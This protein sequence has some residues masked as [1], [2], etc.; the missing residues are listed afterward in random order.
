[1]RKLSCALAALAIAACGGQDSAS[2]ISEIETLPADESV[3]TPGNQLAR[4]AIDSPANTAAPNP[5]AAMPAA[6]HG[7][8]GLT[9]EDC[10]STRGDAKGLVT[11]TADSI[12]FYESVARPAQVQERTER[13]IRGEFAFA[14][15]GMEWT[16]PMIW[17][18]DGNRLVRIDSE[19][20]S[21]LVYTRC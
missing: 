12:R 7:R 1:M 13:I 18:A 21:R 11:I 17:S 19:G 15:E 6:L 3:S 16:G 8:W 4:G 5:A 14:G 20:D 9:R 2:N 10:T